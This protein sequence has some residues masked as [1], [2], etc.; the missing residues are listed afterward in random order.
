MEYEEFI[1][2]FT[3]EVNYNLKMLGVPWRAKYENTGGREK[4]MV[5]IHGG[6]H[7]FPPIKVYDYYQEFLQGMPWGVAARKATQDFF[8]DEI[9][10]CALM[11][12]G[13]FHADMVIPTFMNTEENEELLKIVP[14]SRFEDLAVI[15]QIAYQSLGGINL[16][17]VVTDD[18]LQ[19][20]GL[21]YGELYQMTLDNPRNIDFV[22]MIELHKM[23][24][25]S[26]FISRTACLDAS[27]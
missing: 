15:L 2:L 17:L 9:T 16:N 25:I 19:G 26:S 22:Q 4:V 6:G 10:K 3:H 20:W 5:V 21:R 24:D 11:D 12:M 18:I 7:D 8:Y 14:Y 23:M 27:A 1:Q 13:L